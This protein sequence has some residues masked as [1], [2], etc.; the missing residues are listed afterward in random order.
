VHRIFRRLLEGGKSR[1]N[2]RPDGGFREESFR[3]K[4]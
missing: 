4:F 3:G 1:L 2:L